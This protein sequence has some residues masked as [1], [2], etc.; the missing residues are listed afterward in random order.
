[1]APYRRNK[2]AR[3]KAFEDVAVAAFPSSMRTAALKAA[4][5]L[6]PLLDDG[7]RAGAF[8][9]R[10]AG[11]TIAIPDRLHFPDPPTDDVLVTLSPPAC[12]LVSRST[13]GYVRQRA[14][15]VSLA[16]GDP[17][18]MP[19]TAR[20]LG[21]YVAEIAEDIRLALPSQDR[22]AWRAFVRE[23]R[24]FMRL[25]K[26]RAVSYWNVYYRADYPQRRDFPGLAALRLLEAWAAAD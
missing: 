3:F 17:W 4:R 8:E 5:E 26:A 15:R 20:L 25:L 2:L 6:M 24:A 7:Y 1:M 14:I 9:V 11:E 16:H 18:V 23:N 22:S 21:E 19:F 10:L 13:S 12:C